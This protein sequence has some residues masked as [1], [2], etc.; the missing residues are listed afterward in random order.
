M[1]QQATSVGGLPSNR[2]VCRAGGFPNLV[3]QPRERAIALG[4]SVTRKGM[5]RSPT[6][7]NWRATA[8]GLA[9]NCRRTLS[10]TKGAVEWLSWKEIYLQAPHKRSF[11]MPLFN[12]TMGMC[13]RRKEFL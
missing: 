7:T 10:V 6:W 12:P 2:S 11:P 13:L 4:T 3:S 8:V 1:S 9:C 5:H